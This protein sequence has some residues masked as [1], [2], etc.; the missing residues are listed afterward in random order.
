MIWF[1]LLSQPDSLFLAGL[2]A[3]QE[4]QPQ[5]GRWGQVGL[6][7]MA[8]AALIALAVTLLRIASGAQPPEPAAH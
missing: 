3:I 4:A 7:L 6:G 2:P 8:L 5:T 1:Q